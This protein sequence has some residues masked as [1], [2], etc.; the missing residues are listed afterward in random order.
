MQTTGCADN[1]AVRLQP[2]KPCSKHQVPSSD[3]KPCGR[4][5]LRAFIANAEVL[6]QQVPR[7]S[8]GTELADTGVIPQCGCCCCLQAQWQN[9]TR[10]RFATEQAFGQY[11]P[12][13]FVDNVACPLLIIAGTL[14]AA[15]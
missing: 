13:N 12:I 2:P 5:E 9:L 1:R 11:S 3:D 15:G 10:A 7:H 8:I 4:V 6:Q 14:G